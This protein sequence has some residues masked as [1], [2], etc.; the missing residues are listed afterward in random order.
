MSPAV[1]FKSPDKILKKV[2]FPE[3]FGPKDNISPEL[4]EIEISSKIF[5]P[6]TE[7]LLV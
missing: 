7:N 2:D 6:F 1:G 5:L 3:P 4:S